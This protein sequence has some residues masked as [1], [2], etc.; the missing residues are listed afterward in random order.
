MGELTAGVEDLL[1]T[2]LKRIPGA[3]GEVR[4]AMKASDPGFAGF[5]EAYFSSVNP[6]AVN[7][8]RRHGRM[9]LNLVVVLGEVRFVACDGAGEQRARHL[10]PDRGDA[11]GR[12]TVPPGLWLAFGGVGAGPNLL[13]N[14]ASIEHDPTEA[15]TLPIADLPWSWT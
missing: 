13:L 2:P 8:W 11:Y 9:T 14:L 15:E 3:G 7:G 6:G 12:L 5:G 1:F 4:H 10:T